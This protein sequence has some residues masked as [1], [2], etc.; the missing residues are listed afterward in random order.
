MRIRQ[1]REDHWDRLPTIR[2]QKAVLDNFKS[3]EHGEIVFACGK[4]FVPYG[5]ESDILGLYGQNG[6][7]KTSFIEALAILK[8]LMIGAEVPAV[9]AECVAKGQEMA[10]L[11][12]TFDLQYE[13][14]RIRKVV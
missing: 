5:T 3:V 1:F 9:Y 13:D 10:R 8:L 4:K 2:L 11:E 12:F 14:G 7:G 6:S